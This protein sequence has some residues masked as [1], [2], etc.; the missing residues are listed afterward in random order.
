MK[1]RFGIIQQQ[2]FLKK[3]LLQLQELGQVL[4]LWVRQDRLLAGVG[5]QTA[6]LAF[7]GYTTTASWKQQQ[8]NMMDQLGHLKQDLKYGK[9]IFSR[10]WN[11]NCSFS[12]WG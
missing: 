6:A 2:I 10:L 7:G 8:K 12:I 4:L 1:D 3:Q 11:T 5:T 9:I